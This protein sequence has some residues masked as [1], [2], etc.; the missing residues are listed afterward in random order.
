VRAA[1]RSWPT[2]RQLANPGSSHI[3]TLKFNN[4]KQLGLLLQAGA[5]NAPEPSERIVAKPRILMWFVGK[6]V[7]ESSVNILPI[8]PYAEA[9]EVLW[10]PFANMPLIGAFVK[11]SLRKEFSRCGHDHLRGEVL[12]QCVTSATRRSGLAMNIIW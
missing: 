1:I 3:L 2:F 9:L 4:A 7:H 12:Y 6:H 11:L 5:S 10:S 8:Y